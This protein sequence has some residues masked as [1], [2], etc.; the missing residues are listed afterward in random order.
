MKRR[1]DPT[2]LVLAI[3]ILGVAI[4][5]FNL[6]RAPTE[7]RSPP[8]S[9]GDRSPVGGFG[10]SFVLDNTGF[11]AK[12]AT[13][14]LEKV[15]SD[16]KVWLLL[17]PETRFSRKEAEDLLGWIKKGN[18]LVLSA[19]SVAR[20]DGYGYGFEPIDNPGLKRLNGELKIAPDLDFAAVSTNAGAR[21]GTLPA[22][23]DLKFDA[24]SN[25]RTGVKTTAVSGRKTK[26]NRAHLALG[27]PVG[28][29]LD[30]VDIGKGRVFVAPDGWMF[31]NYG[32]SKA[33][34]AILISNLLRV[35]TPGGAVYFDQRRHGDLK[36]DG[37][38]QDDEPQ[39]LTQWFLRPPVSYG[40][41]QLALVLIGA[42]I[43]AGR[44]LGSPVG[45]QNGGP[46]TRASQFAGA[47]GSL[48]FKVKRPKAA[49]RVIGENFRLRLARRIGLSAS[50]NDTILARRAHEVSG[51]PYELLER[52]LLLSRAPSD[53]ENAVLRE[54]QEME[55]V[56]RVLEG[57]N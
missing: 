37:T 1:F 49:A 25:Y 41:L 43:L 3:L 26:I 39:S 34:N 17:D 54:A 50:E 33:D 4:I 55:N 5:G 45:F 10:L 29:S 21:E 15:P 12:K 11:V 42:A 6:K 22:L 20:L 48:L 30:R 47:M 2:K 31:C 51:L 16:A 13:Q 18:T 24:V 38:S 52:L 44:R 46:T 27:S 28:G 36:S 14:R 32:L 56:L 8:V 53:G 40:I 35:H 57:R 9:F 19:E 23:V 7:Y